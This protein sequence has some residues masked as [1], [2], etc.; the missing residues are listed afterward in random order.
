MGRV[1]KYMLQIHSALARRAPAGTRRNHAAEEEPDLGELS[2]LFT[3]RTR[4][5]G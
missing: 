1:N 3:E 4:G 5:Y 2:G